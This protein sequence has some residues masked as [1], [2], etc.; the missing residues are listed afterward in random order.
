[1]A[2]TLTKEPEV[3]S[4]SKDPMVYEFQT[5]N[6]V[7]S[8][9]T[10]AVNKITFTGGVAVDDVIVI[11][12]AGQELRMVAKAVP[13]LSNE[14][15]AGTSDLNVLLPYF[16]DNYTIEKDF[17]VSIVSGKID[18]TA[19][20]AG[21]KYNIADVTFEAGTITTTV[22]GVDAVVRKNFG[23]YYE[24]WVQKADGTDTVKKI[25]DDVIPV[26]RITSKIDVDI[27]QILHS[28]LVE[29]L[30][31]EF[32]SNAGL[33]IK[34]KRKYY[35]RYA[36][37]FG[38][39]VQVQRLVLGGTKHIV[40]GG[41]SLIGRK[42][43]VG[44][45][46]GS[47]AA[48]DACLRIGDTTR[49]I[50]QEEDQYLY[51]LAT[52]ANVAAKLMAVITYND[53]ST[54]TKYSIAVTALRYNKVYF[55]ASLSVFEPNAAKTVVQYVV[56]V[57]DGD[58][59]NT[60][61]S[62]AYTYVID[63]SVRR[64]VRNFF[65]VNSLGGVDEFS[66]F[67]KGSTEVEF[68]KDSAEKAITD[69]GIEAQEEDYNIESRE[70]FEAATGFRSKREL[71]YM[72]DFFLSNRKYVKNIGKWLPII[73][74]NKRVKER[75]DGQNLNGYKFE[76][77]LAYRDDSLSDSDL[78]EIIGYPLPPQGF[79]GGGNVTI[80]L[81]DTSEIVI[82]ATPTI[83]SSNAVSSNGVAVALATKQNKIAVGTE[84]QYIRGDGTL[85]ILANDINAFFGKEKYNEIL[86][87]VQDGENCIF[88]TAF[89]FVTKSTRLFV[90]GV[91]QML[92]TDYNE[93]SNNQIVFFLAPFSD[94][95]IFIDFTKL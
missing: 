83:G 43:V 40:M 4:L 19:R 38:E 29:D 90:N 84:L 48:V 53:D 33:C 50:L 64:S 85:G 27:S 67:G 87:G 12:W 25:H 21:T 16:R 89:G 32:V 46:Q 81:G 5:D 92:G 9:G 47:S 31:W 54:E 14:F 82:D 36:E 59:G 42:T 62:K 70:F 71:A 7:V 49:Y 18:L 10:A 91:R 77:A 44:L 57:V 86:T 63:Y 61:L 35:V 88:F 78:S 30:P 51:F 45:L 23:V 69:L 95:N 28:E 11:S 24:V 65:Y 52:R 68:Y 6:M 58:N 75:E 80:S 20:N 72:R 56:K 73:V 41:S 1:M 93:V 13:V 3:I 22:A 37:V 94:D 55:K 60:A 34:S 2:L 76:Y 15:L 66:T 8:A 79:L 17:V 39:K 74:S 26:D